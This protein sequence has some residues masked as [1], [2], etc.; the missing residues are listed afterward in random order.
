M[1]FALL[2]MYLASVGCAVMGV[3]LFIGALSYPDDYGSTYFLW[4]GPLMS[5]GGLLCCYLL[6]WVFH[7]E[8]QAHR[9]DC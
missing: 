4:F 8:N 7:R 9:N 1:P 2:R 6:W 3:V 5:V